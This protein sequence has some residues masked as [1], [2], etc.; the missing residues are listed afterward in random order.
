MKPDRDKDR[1]Q[2]VLIG[3]GN[4]LRGDGGVGSV[5]AER[6]A[7]VPPAGWRIL[8]AGVAPEAFTGPIRRWRPNLLVIVDA[9]DMAL[10]AGSLRR[11]T[12]ERLPS[13]D[14][15]HSHH[16]SLRQ[17]C[18]YLSPVVERIVVVAVQPGAVDSAPDEGLTPS[19]AEA[20]AGLVNT[21]SNADIDAIKALD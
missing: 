6:L 3:V 12:A 1:L 20:V 11:L 15:F 5:V 16:P 7:M 19:V 2:C 10:P 18:D 13:L 4:R 8:D 9:V 21:L 17:L 14:C